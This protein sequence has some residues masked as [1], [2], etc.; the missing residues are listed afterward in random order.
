MPRF[1][2]LAIIP[3]LLVFALV[4]AYV[5]LELMVTLALAQAA[6]TEV[7]VIERGLG[8]GRI[9]QLLEERGIIR[10]R[11]LFY[12]YLW[13]YGRSDQ[14]QA[15]TYELSPAMTVAEI[16]QK[17]MRGA[18]VS[19]ER[20][21]TIPEGFTAEEIEVLLKEKGFTVDVKEEMASLGITEGNLFPDTYF[22]KEKA[23]GKEIIRRLHENFLAKTAPLHGAVTAG[24]RTFNEVLIMASLI[25][26]EIP[27]P[28]DRAVAA[29][30]LWK[31]LDAGMPLQVDVT[32]LYAKGIR[33]GRGEERVLSA[34]D[35]QIDS[36]YN[37]Y[38]VAG[39]PPR[40]IANSGLEAIKAAISP[41]ES[42]YWYYLSKPDG[43]TVFSKTFEEH[44][45][46]KATFLR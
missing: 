16:V 11:Y 32:V 31:R 33:G 10:H 46:A 42:E 38:R 34:A 9:G 6:P 18:V 25:E 1:V 45:R 44:T 28:E 43:A 22:F 15:G 40:P 20:R 24:G 3:A 17:L 5:V 29:G 37:T 26:E 7:V 12:Y 19:D 14:L 21:V 39:L 13:R 8:S 4:G 27:I 35:L 2:S 41:V 30:V 36:P 23:T